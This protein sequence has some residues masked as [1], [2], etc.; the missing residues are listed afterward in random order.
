MRYAI[1]TNFLKDLSM[2]EIV[3][4]AGETGVDGIEWGLPTLEEAGGVIGE[5]VRRTEDAGLK[6]AGF[7]N[8]G[9]MWKQDD[10]K[11][12]AEIVASVGGGM[13]RVKHPWIAWDYGESLHQN[14]SWHDIFKMA[15]DSL[16]HLCELSKAHNIRFTMEMHSGALTASALAAAW[17]L[18]DTE[19]EHVGVIYDPGNTIL[20]GNMRP[21]SEVEVL[22][23]HLAYVH[24]KN[25]AF[26]FDGTRLEDPVRRA[27][28]SH[29]SCAPQDGMVDYLEVFFALKLS[30]FDGWVCMEDFF[31]NGAEALPKVR[32]SLAFLKECEQQAP[33]APQEPFT[34][35]NV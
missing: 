12:W 29:R 22:G 4:L 8:G 2:A 30:G 35:F 20:E 26:F 32:D 10:M 27:K 18:K 25:Q 31:K 33:S 11:R 23:D 28:W 7:L 1:N 16:P 15:H 3:R 19:P 14:Q 5:M 24:A 6:V 34:T 13:L 17:L 9:Q 21:R